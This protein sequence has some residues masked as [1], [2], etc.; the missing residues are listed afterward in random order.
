MGQE[1]R[2]SGYCD[3]RRAIY[4]PVIEYMLSLADDAAVVV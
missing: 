1:E 3:L 4:T 2:N